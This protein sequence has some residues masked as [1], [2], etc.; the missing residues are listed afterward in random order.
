M[1]WDWRRPRRKLYSVD[2]V[3]G[4]LD[5]PGKRR[6]PCVRALDRSC[7]LPFVS[8]RVRPSVRMTLPAHK[9]MCARAHINS[10]C[11]AHHTSIALTFG[12]S[13]ARLPVRSLLRT[14]HPTYCWALKASWTL[15]VRPTTPLAPE[16]TKVLKYWRLKRDR[17]HGTTRLEYVIVGGQEVRR[18]SCFGQPMRDQ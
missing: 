4:G 13:C 8:P 12:A 3:P 11:L 5:G 15:I 16:S 9:R 10:R 18:Q 14:S 17:P 6:C 7:T 1:V 2:P